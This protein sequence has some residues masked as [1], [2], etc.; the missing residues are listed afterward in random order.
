[1]TDST[2]VVR[3]CERCSTECSSR[4]WR[5]SQ[6]KK[7]CCGRC[8]VHTRSETRGGAV[9]SKCVDCQHGKEKVARAEEKASR[10]DA[11]DNARWVRNNGERT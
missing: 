9:H 6:C 11:R 4:R 1:M 8:S 10:Q 2:W 7:L 3:N 5:C